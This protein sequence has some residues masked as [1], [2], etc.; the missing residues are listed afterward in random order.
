MKRTW[1]KVV[2]VFLALAMVFLALPEYVKPVKTAKAEGE[3]EDKKIYVLTDSM[4]SMMEKMRIRMRLRSNKVIQNQK[5]HYTL[6]VLKLMK[7][8]FGSFLL[9]TIISACIMEIIICKYTD[10]RHAFM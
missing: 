10:R 9:K 7:S 2:S 3:S 6:M 8:Q 5:E 1:R 4:T